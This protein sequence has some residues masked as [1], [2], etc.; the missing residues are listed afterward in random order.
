[1][2]RLS[3]TFSLGALEI[4]AIS[5]GA[6]DRELGGFFH[7]VEAA[8]WTAALGISDPAQPVPFNF[9]SFL[10]RGMDAPR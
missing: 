8:D 6:P 2:S 3:G 7:G 9:G 5:D 10:I 1:M 4:V